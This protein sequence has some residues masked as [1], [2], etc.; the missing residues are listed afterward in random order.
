MRTLPAVLALVLFACA[1]TDR[2]DSETRDAGSRRTPTGPDPVVLRIPR[3]GGAATAYVYPRLDSVVW[4]SPTALPP[5][6]R[7]LG[8]DPE[9]GLLAFVDSAGDP[10]RLDLRLGAVSRQ[11]D[12]GLR[13]LASADGAA[14]Y[15]VDGSG[16]VVRLT[17]A[18][19]AWTFT[20]PVPARAALPQADGWLLVVA[21]R[22]DET[23]V[24][25]LH[26]PE[27]RI[28]DTLSLPRTTPGV[29]AH[30]L[31]RL[32][33]AADERL[34]GVRSQGLEPVPSVSFEGRVTTV[35]ATPSGDRV[36]VV[37]DSSDEI[38]VVDRYE[39]NVTHR[40][41]LPGPVAALRVDPLGRYLL[42]RPALGDS[43]WIVS[44]SS[45]EL[46]GTVATGWRDD[47]PLV[48]PD[49]AIAVARGDDVVFLSGERWTPGARV[50]GG[51]ADFW[52]PL[53]WSGFRPRAGDIEDPAGI[54]T[55][56]TRPA[57]A[58]T[59]P[60]D[61][62]PWPA[63]APYDTIRPPATDSAAPPAR[64]M[65]PPPRPVPARP[66][67][68]GFYVSFA[69]LL[70]AAR[71]REL[72]AQIAVD[73][74]RARV[75]EGQQAGTTIHRVLLGPYADRAEADRVGRASGR[76]YFILEGAP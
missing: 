14:I 35:A 24:W 33:L 67:T 73:G 61:S 42:A 75:V 71:A 16:K 9:G 46:V 54:A 7:V 32:Y 38:A 5:I 41:D 30:V 3:A 53:S 11:E 74:Q 19:G 20:P 22:G 36:F 15:G 44:L 60:T 59:P 76:T 25:R 70:D 48:A 64:P 29:R 21:E 23:I 68:S 63:P 45:G 31:D 43:A 40:V 52:Y 17:P 57:P 8:F 28:V 49:G 51:A 56:E 4:R 55:R 18:G 72:A 1:P 34:L 50:A 47:L 58:P 2:G 6:A 66:I 13:A 12:A 65:P 62:I 39:E 10:G 69:A 27:S 37:T 26:P